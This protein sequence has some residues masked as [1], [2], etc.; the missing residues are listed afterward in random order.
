MLIHLSKLKIFLSLDPE[1]YCN[2]SH[3]ILAH[4]YNYVDI[5]LFTAALLIIA[6]TRNNQFQYIR[7]KVFHMQPSKKKNWVDLQILILYTRGKS[8]LHLHATFTFVC[9]PF[10]LTYYHLHLHLYGKHYEYTTACTYIICGRTQQM[11]LTSV[12]SGD[13]EPAGWAT[14]QKNNFHSKLFQILYFILCKCIT[15]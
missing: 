8:T 12:T 6:K 9:K 3:Y 4:V 10:T 7:I 11:A 5:R 14:E 1:I 13:R 2:L 15:Y